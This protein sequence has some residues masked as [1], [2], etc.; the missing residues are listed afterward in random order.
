MYPKL[1]IDLAKLKHNTQTL[2][3]LCHNHGIGI[4]AV[5][6]VFCADEAMVSTLLETDLA[7]LADSRLQNIARYPKTGRPKMLLRIAPPNE[8]AD[9]VELCDISLNSELVSLKALAAA[10]Q[11]ADK[12]HGVVLLVD[13]GDLREGIFYKNT[14]LLADTAAFT[15]SHPSLALL[16]IGVNFTCYGAVIPTPKKMQQLCAIVR[17]LEEKFKVRLPLVSGG[18]SSSLHLVLNNLMPKGITNLRLGEA[19]I[20]AHETA[21]QQPIP[22][23]HPNVVT[24]EASLVEIQRKPSYPDGE[25]GLNAF[26]EHPAFEDKGERTRGIL[27]LGRQDT[28]YTG[29]TPLESGVEILGASSDHLL[30]DLTDAEKAH[31][32]GDILSFSMD[33]SAILRGFTSPYVRREYKR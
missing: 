4:S 14:T 12:R 24:V 21:Y 20:C 2:T 29:L 25:I 15:L 23:L 8:A 1:C 10:A 28:D 9:I 3:G 13:L 16:G 27:A 18:N 33:Y 30:V 31:Q 26:G 17:H 32:V 5:T 7:Y 6:K 11:K 22:G 19:I